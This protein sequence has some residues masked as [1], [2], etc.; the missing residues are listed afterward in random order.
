[1][2]RITPRFEEILT[3]RHHKTPEEAEV[4]QLHNGAGGGCY[5]G[6]CAGLEKMRAGAAAAEKSLL[7]F[8]G[9]FWWG[10]L[11]TTTCSASV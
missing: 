2:S 4:H 5:G 6:D 10:G 9:N 11:F 8:S 1:M 7:F 3:A